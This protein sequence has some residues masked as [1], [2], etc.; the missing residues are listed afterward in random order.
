MEQMVDVSTD[1]G[2]IQ[3]INKPNS[4]LKPNKLQ[5]PALIWVKFLAL[6]QSGSVCAV[7]Y[8]TVKH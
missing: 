2:Y 1:S 8:E 6:N 3:T 5:L 4:I 7:I